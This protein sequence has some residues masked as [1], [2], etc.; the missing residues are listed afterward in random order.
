MSLYK[1]ENIQSIEYTR[2]VFRIK[3][4]LTGW[5]N[6]RCPYCIDRFNKEEKGHWNKFDLLLTRAKNINKFLRYN[7]ITKSIHLSILGGEVTYLDLKSIVSEIDNISNLNLTTNFSRELNYFEDLF[8]WCRSKN[9]KLFINC[10]YHEQNKNFTEKFLELTEWCKLNHFSTPRVSRVIV[11]DLDIEDWLKPYTDAGITKIMLTRNKDA[12]TDAF[13]LFDS[14]QEK[15]S[16]D[17]ASKYEFS[18][19]NKP[20]DFK[21]TLKDGT[22]LYFS[23][24]SHFLNNLDNDGFIPNGF[25][26]NCGKN[27]V[28][29]N[30]DGNV[31]GSHC[32]ELADKPMG[33]IDQDQIKLSDKLYYCNNSKI[34]CC[35]RNGTSVY[36][37]SNN[38]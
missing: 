19:D 27:G 18:K 24:I 5:C 36:R 37:N 6:F 34:R 20:K 29:I 33:N 13:N 4:R 8:V 16:I 2:D 15:D 35:V 17:L 30:W 25:N 31:Y 22:K 12:H 32:F 14:K 7:N 28:M 9:I 23:S 21:I 3:W 11:D 1:N 38:N 26:C 10:S